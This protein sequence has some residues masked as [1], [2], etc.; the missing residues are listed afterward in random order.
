MTRR[1]F[2]KTWFGRRRTRQWR[3]NASVARTP[4][5]AVSETSS[6]DYVLWFLAG[7]R[8]AC[9]PYLLTYLIVDQSLCDGWK[10][11]DSRPVSKLKTNAVGWKY[12]SLLLEFAI[13]FDSFL[14]AWHLI[15]FDTQTRLCRLQSVL[16]HSFNIFFR[17]SYRI[18]HSHLCFF[19]I[20]WFYVSDNVIGVLQC[21]VLCMDNGIWLLPRV[22]AIYCRPTSIN[23]HHLLAYYAIVEYTVKAV[24]ACTA[25]LHLQQN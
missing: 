5:S 18:V 11:C 25:Y 12:R 20:R 16:L 10:K 9:I 1:C 4:S 14:F 13:S 24:D 6:Y 8:A 3:W 19:R 7:I 23:Y 17:T 15:R 21:K 22:K 2:Q